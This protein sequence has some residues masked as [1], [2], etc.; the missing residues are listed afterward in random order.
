M[1]IELAVRT[2]RGGAAHLWHRLPGKGS[3]SRSAR[4]RRV[5]K[6]ATSLSARCRVLRLGSRRLHRP[7][8]ESHPHYKAKQIVACI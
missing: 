5:M 7:P 6:V 8:L 1:K 2:Y 4:T 3:S